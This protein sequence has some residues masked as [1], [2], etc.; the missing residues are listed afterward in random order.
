MDLKSTLIWTMTQHPVL[1]NQAHSC[2]LKFVFVFAEE[3]TQKK[4]GTNA[5]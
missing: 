4:T 3:Y 5:D 2:V 1:I